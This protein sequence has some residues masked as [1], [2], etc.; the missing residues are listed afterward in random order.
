MSNQRLLHL[1]GRRALRAAALIM[2]AVAALLAAPAALADDPPPPEQVVWRCRLHPAGPTALI[3]ERAGSVAV[4]DPPASPLDD[5]LAVR[6]ALFSQPGGNITWLVRTQP[7]QYADAL[8]QVPLHTVPYD[9]IRV[10][11]LAE[12]LMCG[13]EPA[14]RVELATLPAPMAAVR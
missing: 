4:T 5:A 14:C 7:A 10:Q 11:L 9:N 8:W 2:L 13:S 6:R 1:A 12:I 3:C